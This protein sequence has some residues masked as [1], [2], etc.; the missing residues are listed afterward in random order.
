MFLFIMKVFIDSV[1]YLPRV[2]V[3]LSHFITRCNVISLIYQ[4]QTNKHTSNLKKIKNTPPP[5]PRLLFPDSS[6]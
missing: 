5:P 6:I 4:R 3:M 2:R 1:E